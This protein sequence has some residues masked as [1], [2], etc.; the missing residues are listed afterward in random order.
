MQ[1]ELSSIP[2]T[3]GIYLFKDKQGRILYVGKAK[4]LRKRVASYFRGQSRHSPKTTAMLANAESL[5]TLSTNTEKEALLLEAS[6][7][8][9]HRPRYNVVLKDDKQYLLFCID[10]THPFPKLSIVRP[11][12]DDSKGAKDV[13][14]GIEDAEAIQVGA[15]SSKHKSVFYGPYTS[16]LAARETWRVIHR[17]FPLRRCTNRSF[18][19]RV[20]PCLYYHLGQCLGPCVMPVPEDEYAAVVQRVDMFLNGRS[21]ELI[22]Q[23]HADMQEASDELNFEQ[24]AKFRDQIKAV[25]LTLEKQSAVMQGTGSLDAVGIAEVKGDDG[26]NGL[27]LGILF[28][29]RGRVLGGKTYFWPGLTLAEGPEVIT[30]FLVQFYESATLIP[31]RILLPWALPSDEDDYSDTMAD[32]YV[33]ETSAAGEMFVLQELLSDKRGSAVYLS[34][35]R[36]SVEKLLVNMASTNAKESAIKEKRPEIAELLAGRLHIQDPIQ[37]IECVDVS[38]TSGK[39][40]RV[41]LVVYE[42]GK[43]LRDEFRS[44]IVKDK[45]IAPGDDYGV[46]AHWAMRRVKSGPPWPDLVLVDGGKGQLAAVAKALEEAV[47]ENDIEV[48]F[49]LA[50]IAKA[51]TEHGK[52]DRRAGNVSDLIFLPGR[53]NPLNLKPGSP[54]LLFLQ[55]VRDSA[56]DQAIGRHRKARNK[57]ALAG[58]LERLSGVGP[59]T[60]KLLWDNFNSLSEMAS[61][62]E[63]E[64]AKLPGIGKI[65]AKSLYQELQKLNVATS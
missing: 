16:A 56:H 25:E 35:P 4:H 7:I 45:N 1:I 21:S 19:N 40:T 44:Y 30:S 58:E 53:S 2:T 6:L 38:H 22:E 39:D 23:L 37:R 9:K 29:R 8:K 63:H 54:E 60:A 42:N 18:K 5:D 12:L 32:E 50:S 3:P 41:G 13:T 15:K 24:A 17:I 46:L 20:R 26:K 57:A 31:T 36:S 55:M 47:L 48:S 61:A 14:F 59:K 33:D 27:G 28:V 65:K 52:P 64:L 43:P 51:R 10:K 49:K 11:R 62:S 34:V